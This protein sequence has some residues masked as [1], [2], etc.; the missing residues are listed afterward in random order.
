MYGL[1]WRVCA[2]SDSDC[3]ERDVPKVNIAQL[4]KLN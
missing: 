2:A 4:Y 1:R 3:V